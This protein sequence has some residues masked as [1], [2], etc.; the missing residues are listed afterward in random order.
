M[1]K[2]RSDVLFSDPAIRRGRARSSSAGRRSRSK[3]TESNSRETIL[4][5]GAQARRKQRESDTES[6]YTQ[7]SFEDLLRKQNEKSQ[8]KQSGKSDS[9]RSNNGSASGSEMPRAKDKEEQ[10][11]FTPIAA[12]SES[13]TCL[14]KLSERQGDTGSYTYRENVMDLGVIPSG[15]K[16]PVKGRLPKH[17]SE[18]ASA[19]TGSGD[20]LAVDSGRRDTPKSAR[21]GSDTPENS[22]G[23]RGHQPMP[24]SSSTPEMSGLASD[25]ESDCPVS[26]GVAGR[27]RAQH[28]QSLLKEL[29]VGHKSSPSSS[30]SD[31][32]RREA[33]KPKGVA[34]EDAKPQIG[35]GR[36]A[37]LQFYTTKG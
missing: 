34:R 12:G 16:E 9:E 31:T 18:E 36:A 2:Y 5:L 32:E 11:G 21:N 28:L 23:G 4:N 22:S 6:N 14:A 7:E 27:G 17:A 26:R 33:G 8:A 10:K 30:S 20:S 1:Q 35:A 29:S 37:M 19:Y 3:S 25:S 13:A 15:S 24:S